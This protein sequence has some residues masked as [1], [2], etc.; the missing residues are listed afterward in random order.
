MAF[1]LIVTAQL[2][3]YLDTFQIDLKIPPTIK[4]MIK[5]RVENLLKTEKVFLVK[6]KNQKQIQKSF[7]LFK[8]ESKISF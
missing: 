7:E 1:I 5:K 2:K 8:I 3:S 6:V 4:I